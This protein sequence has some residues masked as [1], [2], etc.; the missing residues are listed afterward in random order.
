MEEAKKKQT[1]I[2]DED[3]KWILTVP[4]IQSDPAKTFMRKAAVEICA[5]FLAYS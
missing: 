5:S 3:I 4:E 1:D 2:G